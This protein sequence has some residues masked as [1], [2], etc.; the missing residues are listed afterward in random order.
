[1]D[2]ELL[3]IILVDGLVYASYLF[4]VSVGLTVICGVLKILNVTHGAF[5]AFGAYLTA[6]LLIVYANTGWPQIGAF[7]IMLLSAIALGIVFGIV[8]ER[9]LLKHLY[10]QD[11]HIVVLA[12]FAAFL[13][14]EDVLLLIWGTTPYIASEPLA[15]LGMTEIAQLP[16]D[17]Y[18]L[19]MILLSGITAF[20][21][22]YGLNRTTFGKLLLAVIY[23]RELSQAMGINVTKVFLLTFMVGAFLGALGGAYQAPTISVLPGIGIEV[24]VLA[25]AVVVIGGMGSIPGALIGSVVVGIARAAAV[26]LEP[27][28]ELFVIYAIMAIV[29]IIRPQGLFA[30]AKARKI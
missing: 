28:F 3:L 4:M 16:F 2:F 14:L 18:N 10:H 22:W 6:D 9:G 26:H 23:D 11:E 19:S 20:L 30:P 27:V 12:T 8:I 29:L 7:P 1:M 17:N 24:I 13:A 5:Y 25:F 15:L 21:L